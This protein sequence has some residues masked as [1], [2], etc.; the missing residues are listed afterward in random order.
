MA[1]KNRT[2]YA[3]RIVNETVSHVTSGLRNDLQQ[4]LISDYDNF[5]N[6]CKPIN[7][8]SPAE[9]VLACYIPLTQ[10][11]DGIS[12][13]MW[14]IAPSMDMPKIPRALFSQADVKAEDVPDDPNV[15]PNDKSRL[16]INY[17]LISDDFLIS[18]F[19]PSRS[20][21]F[22]KYLNELLA[23]YRGGR[24]YKFDPLV[25]LPEDIK[26]SDI[27][28][29]TFSDKPVLENGKIKSGKSK[30]GIFKTGGLVLKNMFDDYGSTNDLINQK[31]LSATMTLKLSKPRK[32][33]D[34]VYQ[35]KLSAI[36][37]PLSAGDVEGVT[38]KLKDGKQIKAMTIQAKM[39]H[40]FNNDND[41]TKENVM[42]AYTVM[43]NYLTS[44]R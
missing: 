19:P 24:V 2:F 33:S 38:F 14:R 1:T 17:F 44:L 3:Y 26:L 13:E 16:D 32:M 40:T 34:E 27:S 5:G 29:V 8:G 30:Y 10:T 28:S 36:L 25:I 21:A 31:I 35:Q 15:S 7:D 39:Q 9:D 22:A 42:N 20:V 43:S 37:K 23:V 18:S 12:G 11:P 41:M 4:K 6:R